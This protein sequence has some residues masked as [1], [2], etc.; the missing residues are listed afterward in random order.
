MMNA[1]SVT[2]KMTFPEF[3]KLNFKILYAKNWVL[4]ITIFSAL[5]VIASIVM[6]MVHYYTIINSDYYGFGVG[7]ATMAVTLPLTVF[8]VAKKGFK[9]NSMLQEYI[10]YE[11]SEEGIKTSGESFS[12]EY[13]WQKLH[14]A[15]FTSDWLLLYHSKTAANFV[16]IKEVNTADIEN[17]KLLL[18]E[19]GIKVKVLN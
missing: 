19:K 3:R 6:S 13:K 17:L 2:T 12:S 9:S 7:L 4:A 14:R 18:N 1:F 10:T 8:F 15:G 16:K 5:F 11:F